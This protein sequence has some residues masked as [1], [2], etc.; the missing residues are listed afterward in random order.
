MG[1]GPRIHAPRTPAPTA[2]TPSTA[3]PA[4]TRSAAASHPKVP[5]TTVNNYVAAP[6]RLSAVGSGLGK[7]AQVG[8]A[9]VLYLQTRKDVESIAAGLGNALG[10]LGSGAN[11]EFGK[12]KD[13]L[14]SLLSG[15]PGGIGNAVGVAGGSALSLVV[16]GGVVY[17]VYEVSR[18]M[19]FF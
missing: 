4:S 19:N 5:H 11:Q 3:I 7:A 12:F 2:P 16:I 9:G 1:R 8:G 10:L 6:S 17:V 18:A 13:E 14:A 15:V